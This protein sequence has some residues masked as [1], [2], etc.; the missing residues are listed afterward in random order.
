MLQPG[1]T[2]LVAARMR[3]DERRS[4]VDLHRAAPETDVQAAADVAVGDGVAGA[5]SLEVAVG[6]DIGGRPGHQ[7]PG[8]GRQRQERHLLSGQERLERSLTGGAVAALSGDRQR[9]LAGRLPHLRDAP[10]RPVPEEALPRVVHRPLHAGLVLGAGNPGWVDDAAVVA[11]KLAVG[12]VDAGVVAV[13]AEDAG[14]EVVRHQPPGCAAEEAERL[15]VG[16]Q[17]GAGVFSQHRV[18][19]QVT[20]MREGHQEGIEP[21]LP[22]GVRVVPAAGVEEVDLRLRSRRWVV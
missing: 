10:E 21:P 14:A 18:E 22:T 15:H 11:G 3:G 4:L 8:P 19:E 9:P 16:L 7:L 6:M 13:G 2:A 17:P 1:G 20:A 5:A 12:P